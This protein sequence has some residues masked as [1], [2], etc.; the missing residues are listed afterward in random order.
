MAIYEEFLAIH[1]EALKAAEHAYSTGDTSSVG[2]FMHPD[3]HGY[4]G[5]SSSLS[6]DQ[7]GYDDCIEGMRKTAK[8]YPGVKSSISNRYVRMR[9]ESEAIVFYD[10]SMDTGQAVIHAMVMEVWRRVGERWV[11]VREVTEHA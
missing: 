11:I 4:F 6:A 8:A 5:T 3:L 1:D 2:M 7:Y 9:S 10:K